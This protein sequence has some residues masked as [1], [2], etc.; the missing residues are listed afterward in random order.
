MPLVPA[1]SRDMGMSP[2][3]SWP[4]TNR[5]TTVSEPSP[6]RTMPRRSG[7][8]GSQA[9]VNRSVTSLSSSPC[10]ANSAWMGSTAAALPK[11]RAS[12]TAASVW[13][14]EVRL[15]RS[16]ERNTPTRARVSAETVT[17]ASN[18]RNASTGSSRNTRTVPRVSNSP[19]S[20]TE[21]SS[22]VTSGPKP[23]SVVHPLPSSIPDGRVNESDQ[24][25]LASWSTMRAAWASAYWR[26]GSAGS[27][28]NSA[29]SP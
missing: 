26:S 27:R 20:L 29:S 11:A 5:S 4:S 10:L 14:S 3:T 1:K 25:S 15:T 28:R 24:T 23:M 8:P 12:R 9:V 19:A 6:R 13:L 7:T 17:S 2:M 21:P 16:R 22:R 18:D